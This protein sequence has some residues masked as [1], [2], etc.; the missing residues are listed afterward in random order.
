MLELPKHAL[1]AGAQMEV[2]AHPEVWGP[3]TFAG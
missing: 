3:I 2:E 1:G